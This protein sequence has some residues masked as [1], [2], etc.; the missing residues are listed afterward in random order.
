MDDNLVVMGERI[1]RLRLARDLRV[2][3]LAA[4]ADLSVAQVYRLQNDERP[5]VSAVVLARIAGALD[6]T[7]D[8]L[9]GLTNDERDIHNTKEFKPR[10]ENMCSEAN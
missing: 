1:R 2:E 4:R 3:E 10:E 5:N 9:L 8:Y 7:L 6:T